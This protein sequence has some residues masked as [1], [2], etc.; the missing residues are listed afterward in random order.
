MFDTTLTEQE[1]LDYYQNS[2]FTYKNKAVV[3]LQ[4]RN[5]DHDIAN[6]KS[7]DSSHHGNHATLHGGV[8]KD[9]KHGYSFDGVDGYL[10]VGDIGS[11]NAVS[12][13]FN[14]A[15]DTEDIIDMDGGAHTIEVNAGTLTATGFDTPIITVNGVASTA[16]QVGQW[17]VV[18]ITTETAFNASAFKI[19]M[20]TTYFE[21]RIKNV[22]ANHLE[23]TSLQAI[24]NYLFMIKGLN[25]L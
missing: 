10:D 3:D 16:I 13:M 6:N 24:D 20:E 4:F 1:A 12:F 22:I 7:L 5:Q 17:Q 11:V 23:M 15:S 21:G 8:T 14:P 25:Q 19:G 18:T 2:T 9:D